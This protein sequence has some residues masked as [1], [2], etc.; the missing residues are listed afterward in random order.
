M[1]RILPGSP[2]VSRRPTTSVNRPVALPNT[3]GEGRVPATSGGGS[4]PTS[5]QMPRGV[6]PLDDS[7]LLERRGSSSAPIE[8]TARNPQIQDGATQ[9]TQDYFQVRHS[10]QLQTLVR[11]AEGKSSQ[12]PR[13]PGS[14]PS[15]QNLQNPQN[16][17]NLQNLQ[18]LQSLQ[19]L[20]TP[21]PPNEKT[22]GA[23][24]ERSEYE[25]AQGGFRNRFT[26][27]T[28]SWVGEDRFLDGRGW[29]EPRAFTE[30]LPEPMT[31]PRSVQSLTMEG[32]FPLEYGGPLYQQQR[33]QV[34]LTNSRLQSQVTA[35]PQRV[36]KGEARAAKWKRRPGDRSPE[37]IRHWGV[38]TPRPVWNPPGPE[39]E[40]GR[41]IREA[42][43]GRFE[44]CLMK[45]QEK[46]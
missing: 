16:L 17:Q 28:P 11:A 46:L 14:R 9:I 10:E 3:R 12:Q 26:Q 19:N 1:G 35:L 4:R 33:H 2:P 42:E 23:G 40:N 22:V 31:L 41:A 18:D 7:L 38:P 13:R 24:P 37:T 45:T 15:A 36:Q 44:S 43:G 8:P 29:Q 39:L 5:S 20:Q 32:Q 6:M 34:P 27:H 21:R 30:H 25:A